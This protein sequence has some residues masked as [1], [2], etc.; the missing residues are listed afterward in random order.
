MM[1]SKEKEEPEGSISYYMLRAPLVPC[2]KQNKKI[3]TLCVLK[4]RDFLEFFLND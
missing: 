1:L 4:V 2:V 3:E